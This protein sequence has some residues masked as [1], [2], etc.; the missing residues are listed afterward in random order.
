MMGM[1]Y[2]LIVVLITRVHILLKTHQILYLKSGHYI[3]WKL[4]LYKIDLKTKETNKKNQISN[5]YVY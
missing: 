5:T 2:I 1:F 3:E 4:Y